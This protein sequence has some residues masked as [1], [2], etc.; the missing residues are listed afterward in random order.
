LQFRPKTSRLTRVGETPYGQRAQKTPQE[1][2]Q[3]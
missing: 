2:A 1:D 3:T